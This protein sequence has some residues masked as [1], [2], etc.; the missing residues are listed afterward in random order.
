[1]SWI[2]I[3]VILTTFSILGSSRIIV[4]IKA[5]AVQG[6]LLSVLHFMVRGAKFDLHS[7]IL[8][9]ITFAIKTIAIPLL[10][11]RS[12]KG[13]ATGFRAEPRIGSHILLLVGGI[14]A[15]MSFSGIEYFPLT[16]RP[17]ISPLL[18]PTALTTVLIGFLILVTKTKATN[19]IIGFLV[20]ENGIF[21][22]GMTIIDTFP[23]MVEVGVLLDVLVGVFVMGI[24]IYHIGRTFDNIDTRELRALGDSE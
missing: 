7:A 5:I 4:R 23:M 21:A 13:V 11:Y 15:V 9:F 2:L 8:V 12:T 16:A 6:A 20:L 10:I 3:G 18:I 24:M 14:I 19:Q 22:F 17:D 1:V